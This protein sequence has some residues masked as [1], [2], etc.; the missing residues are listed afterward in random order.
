MMNEKFRNTIVGI[1]I[2]IAAGLLTWG[3]F[4]L[5]RLPPIGPYAP[6]HVT[7][8]A[9]NADRLNAGDPVDLNGVI[10]GSVA[11]VTLAHHL[12]GVRVVL[13]I[14][15]SVRLPVNT[16]VRIG[17]QT[18]G[19]SYV[20]MTIPIPPAQRFLPTDGTA[21]LPATVA[22]S[23]FLPPTVIRD[24]SSIARRFD[25]LSTRLDRVADDLHTLLK[26]VALS[27]PE[28]TGE[29][30]IAADMNNISAL[31]QRLNT[32]VNSLNRL[33]AD[34]KLQHQVRE[35]IANAAAAS[36]ELKATLQ[37]FNAAA[38]AFH[39]AIAQ[40]GDAAGQVDRAAK[41]IREQV[42]ALSI[43]LSQILSHI[44]TITATIAAGHGT[45]GRFVNDPRLYNALLD[46]T[47][48]LKRTVDALHALVKQ[49]RAEGF[50]VHVGL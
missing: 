7:L 46:V 48:R 18:I 44:N 30:P 1:T 45:A 41:V 2:L 15:Q 42:V 25:Q 29:A 20:A 23:S 13:N 16:Q 31:I 28:R 32:T 35:I 34:R 50:D 8:L 11:E 39:G 19:A 9:P 24:F 12:Q 36:R 38:G 47:H 17:A 5:G 3:A 14:Y 37:H 21:R 33:L 43:Q 10:V 4:L 26:P 22:S 49:V 6:Y 40:A 27:Q